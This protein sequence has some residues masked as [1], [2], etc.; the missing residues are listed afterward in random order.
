[1]NRDSKIDQ[2]DRR[3]IKSDILTRVRFLYLFF[4][5]AAIVITLR[6]VWIQHF[7]NDVAINADK[8]I[9][10][11][12]IHNQKIKALRGS[13]LSRDGEALVTSILR[14]QVEVDFGSTGF[15]DETEYER[16]SDSLSKLLALYFRDK[17][18]KE[19]KKI[20]EEERKKHYQLTYLKDTLVTRSEGWLNR[21][22]DWM[23]D[24]SMEQ[25]KLYDTIRDHKRVSIFPK[26]V[27]YAEWQ[28]LRHYPI[29]NWNMGFTYNLVDAEERIYTKGDVAKRTLGSIKEGMEQPYGID[30]VFDSLL[31]GRDGVEQRQ[32]IARGF[33]GRV[34]GGESQ[35][36][37]N[38]HDIVTTL[39]SRIQDI[40]HAALLKQAEK[41][42]VDW[43]TTV[44][45]E[46][47]T[48]DILAMSN[49]KRMNS[50]RYEE[51]RNHAIGARSEPGSTFKLAAMMALLEDAKMP[52]SQIYNSENGNRVYVGK[53]QV[54]DSHAGGYNVNL[55]KAFI[56]SLNVYF[57]KAIN[58]HY[59]S[60]PN[61]YVNFLRSIN[62]DSTVGLDI[63]GEPTPIIFDKSSDK[64]SDD[65]TLIYMAYGYALELS[66]IQ[67]LT[68]YNAVANNGR[69][70]APRLIKEIKHEGRI[71]EQFETKVIKERICSQS[72]LDTLRH[73]LT[74]VANKKN[75][76]A[77]PYLGHFNDFSVA[78][79]T[80]T[81]QFAQDG[82]THDDG[83]YISSMVGYIPA[84]N[85]KYSVITTF[86]VNVKNTRNI[87]GGALAGPVL[88]DVMQQLYNGENEWQTHLETLQ[89]DS[90]PSNIKSG[91]IAS[92]RRVASELSPNSRRINKRQGWGE[93]V[94][95]SLNRVT[96]K[97]MEFEEG[98]MPN[99]V[100][101]GL[102]D[103]I[104]LLESRGIR[105]KFEGTGAIWRQSLKAGSK[106]EKGSVVTLYLR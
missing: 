52:T 21:L 59:R 30:A 102:R 38:G 35:E 78:A 84:E 98:V 61:K 24:E 87:Y 94:Y 66:P 81:A 13:I 89:G 8:V 100:G 34:V 9:Q 49:V 15:D 10:G 53:V 29:L 99:L 7:S 101:F 1:M 12:I 31:R 26:A 2:H 43:G 5:V 83:I 55:H 20:F 42:K 18:A 27:D 57:T 76:T 11:R 73:Y 4:I 106:L 74:D 70:V 72:T 39:D 36:A 69:M 23:R 54:E 58:D 6:I 93:V 44:V 32:R 62:L 37:V 85:P 95:D 33:Y 63:Y 45:M 77:Y 92:I 64:W 71:V 96:V 82:Y 75:G 65:A 103:A 68:L 79:K 14:Y 16:Q 3:E 47:A 48:G 56:E 17:S 41:Y 25:I 60:D 80:G 105:V 90:S 40:V 97:D 46:V 91:D 88:R 19:Y 28:T 104:F 51:E 50:G 86:R 67:I 22:V